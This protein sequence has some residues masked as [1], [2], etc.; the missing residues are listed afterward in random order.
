MH[1]FSSGRKKVGRLAIESELQLIK[2]ITEGDRYTIIFLV[3]KI[4]A[5]EL[6]SE[7]VLE[8]KVDN[9]SVKKRVVKILRSTRIAGTCVTHTKFYFSFRGERI[10]HRT[11]RDIIDYGNSVEYWG[12]KVKRN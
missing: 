10:L 8:K 9:K 5:I 11:N 4:L 6:V 1:T 7:I 3:W 2:F 12:K